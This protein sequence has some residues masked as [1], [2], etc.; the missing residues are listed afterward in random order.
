MLPRHIATA[1]GLLA[2]LRS[3]H[4]ARTCSTRVWP[5]AQPGRRCARR[6]MMRVALPCAVTP[7]SGCVGVQHLCT[8]WTR[9]PCARL[10][11]CGQRWARRCTC[12][13]GPWWRPIC[14][15]TRGGEA[16]SAGLRRERL[17]KCCA[18]GHGHQRGPF[19]RTGARH[20][21]RAAFLH[22]AVGLQCALRQ[23]RRHRGGGGQCPLR[24]CTA[25]HETGGRAQRGQRSR[26]L[27][28]RL[29]LRI[30][31]HSSDR[32]VAVQSSYCRGR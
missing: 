10:A 5:I 30:R 9:L 2:P 15:R 22:S 12:K 8:G 16:M 27:A 1:V 20:G 25:L 3:C 4:A 31:R 13:A 24:G 6:C 7:A 28:L 17:C 18:L 23:L 26:G 21:V 19:R 29:L 32:R 14:L 11:M